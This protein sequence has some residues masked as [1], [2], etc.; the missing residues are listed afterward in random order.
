MLGWISSAPAKVAKPQSV[1]AMTF[2]RPTISAYLTMRCA[3][4]SG[5]S[6]ST[7]ECEITPGIRIV[8]SGSFASRHTVHSCSW[9]GFE[10][11][12]E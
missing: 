9:R 3:T 7:V 10:A 12:N 8:P 6:T 1:P 11:S 2:S 5:C 4:S